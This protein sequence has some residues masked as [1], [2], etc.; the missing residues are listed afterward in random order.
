MDSTYSYHVGNYVQISLHIFAAQILR[1]E[2]KNKLTKARNTEEIISDFS[3]NLIMV[4][5]LSLLAYV[6]GG[7]GGLRHIAV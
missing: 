2:K 6:T 5:L 7:E 4:L 1:K 3:V